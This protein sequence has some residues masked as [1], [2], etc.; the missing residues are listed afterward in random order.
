M[1]QIKNENL[2]ISSS[3]KKS[4]R[5]S[6]ILA[7]N[8]GLG[9][10]I[11]RIPLC[12]NEGMSVDDTILFLKSELAG[13]C[14]RVTFHAMFSDVNISSG[15]FEIRRISRRRFIESFEIASAIGA[16]TVL[17]HTGYKG[18]KHY[19]SIYQFK[20]K[21]TEFWSNFICEFEST[22]IIAVIENVF[23][24]TPEFCLELYDKIDSNNFKLA[25]D[26]GH[27]NIYAQNTSV[28][29]W[30]QQYGHKLYHMHI[31]N[32]F[33]ENDDHSNLLNGTLNFCDIFN[34]LE[35][36]KL[37]PSFV[38]EMY[39]EEDILSSVEYINKWNKR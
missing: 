5:E 4:I 25:L 32:N 7:H 16:D 20:K 30:I 35:T 17:F 1:N 27:V 2:L 9:L 28:S 6:A 37:N 26:T 19:G 29:E 14:N 21:F 36:E 10:E 3:A 23:E 38:L 11:S 15:D 24:T 22:G 12:K 34:T 31:H 8:L 33:R 13:F 18:T 39:S